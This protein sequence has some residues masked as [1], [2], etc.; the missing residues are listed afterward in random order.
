MCTRFQNDQIRHDPHSLALQHLPFRAALA[1]L[2]MQ[3]LQI[4]DVP[5]LFDQ[6]IEV[7]GQS[8]VNKPPWH[9]DLLGDVV[10]LEFLEFALADRHDADVAMQLAAQ[11]WPLPLG[12]MRIRSL[13]LPAHRDTCAAHG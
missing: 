10:N 7:T 9:M 13:S 4:E 12:R 1:H 2:R 5:V 8:A 11:A 6:A 3:A